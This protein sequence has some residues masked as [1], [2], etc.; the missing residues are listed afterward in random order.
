MKV[1]YADVV[2]QD[3]V[4]CSLQGRDGATIKGMAFRSAEQPLGQLI[5]GSRGQMIHVAGTPENQQLERPHHGRDIY[6]RCG[7]G[8]LKIRR[9]ATI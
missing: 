8:P 2:G 4:K 6:R 5:L 9:A 3:H 7:T 1:T